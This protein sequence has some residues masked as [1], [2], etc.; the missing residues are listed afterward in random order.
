M[1]VMRWTFI[2]V[3]RY[4]GAMPGVPAGSG[5]P[6]HPF[7]VVFAVSVALYLGFG[8]LLHGGDDHGGS[9]CKAAVCL[10]LA[11]VVARRMTIRPRQNHLQSQAWPSLRGLAAPLARIVQVAVPPRGSPA[12][13][14][15]LRC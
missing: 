3:T 4:A 14:N 2:L 8:L 5:Q 10:I 6:S 12:V 7:L 15:I 1:A 9:D 13:S 11:A